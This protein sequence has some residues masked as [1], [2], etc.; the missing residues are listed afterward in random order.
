MYCCGVS[1]VL[2]AGCGYVGTALALRL[3]RAGHKVWGLRRRG[4]LLPEPVHAISADLTQERTLQSLP[5][6]LDVVFYTTA[7]DDSSERAYTA[8]YVTGPH[9]LIAALQKR[10]MRPRFIFTSSTAVYA[11]QGGQWVD[12]ESETEPTHFSGTLLLR[13][14]S[15]LSQSGLSHVILRLGGIY[16]PG[17]ESLLSSVREGRATYAE[18]APRYTNRIHRDDCAG[19]LQ[20]LGLLESPDE[21]YLGVD[22]EPADR[23]VVLEYL[24][25]LLSVPAPEPSTEPTRRRRGGSNKRCSNKRLKASGYQLEFPSFR[26]GYAAMVQAE[27]NSGP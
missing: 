14:E 25:S 3:V 10:Q 22:D 20:H 23:R 13:S 15:A 5:G 12:E 16:G 4:D 19:A 17:R 21:L 6:D 26:D 18:G 9:T 7:A 1:R 2:V 24:A 11:Q 27:V 8:A